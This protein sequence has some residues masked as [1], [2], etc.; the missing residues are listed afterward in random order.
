MTLRALVL[1]TVATAAFASASMTARAAAPDPAAVTAVAAVAGYQ[2]AD[3]TRRLIEG[4]KKEGELSLYSS[5][6]AEDLADLNGAFEKKYGIKVKL[7]RAASDTILQRALTEA[8]ANRFDADVVDVSTPML[9][10]MHRE[11][12]L[13]PVASPYLA[14]LIPQAL[15]AHREWVGTRLNVFVHAYNTSLVKKED[16]PKT[17]D[18]LLDPKW[19]GKL[20]IEATDED[21]FATL[22]AAMGEKKGLQLFRDIKAT[23]GLSVRKGHTLL[24]KMVASGE[25]PFALTVYNFTADQLKQKGAPLDWYVMSPAIARA[26]GLGVMRRAPHPNAAVLYY[27][28]IISDE[29]QQILLQRGFMPSSI[30]I[31]TPFSKMA[32]KVVDPAQMLDDGDKWTRLYD[33]IVVKGKN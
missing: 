30:R 29:G 11:R 25:V 8:Q 17:Y 13:V 31:Q 28:F 26:N 10:A 19:K 5:L 18:D 2:G 20:S 12:M 7:W 14:E 27:D 21:W 32:L 9:E 23:N 33:Q 15:P 3:R 16:L 6:T 24:T 4:A 22:V 1:A